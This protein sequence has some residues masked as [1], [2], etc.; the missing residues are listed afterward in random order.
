MPRSRHMSMMSSALVKKNR[1]K[2]ILPDLNLL[3]YCIP[4]H[5]LLYL[6]LVRSLGS[7]HQ[8]MGIKK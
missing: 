2:S 6:R 3:T 7:Q 5:I 1:K 4:T 8:H